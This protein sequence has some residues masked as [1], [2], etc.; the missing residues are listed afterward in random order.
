M[1]Q[2]PTTPAGYFAAALAAGKKMAEPALLVIN[3]T[4]VLLHDERLKLTAFEDQRE[5]PHRIKKTVETTDAQSF[6]DYFN[7]FADDNSTIFVDVENRSFL[8]V[9]DYHEGSAD[10]EAANTPRHGSHLV[11]YKCPLTPEAK[12][13]L[14]NNAAKKNQT[15]FAEF[16]EEGA[17]EI[18]EPSAA[19]M[20]EIALTMQAKTGVDFS[21]GIR[22]DNGQVQLTYREDIQG[23]AGTTGQMKIPSK[24]ALGI[25]LFQGGDRYRVEANFR[26]RL[27][28]GRMTL[29]YDLIRPHIAL[30][31]AVKQ[32]QEKIKA[33]MSKGQLI[34]AKHG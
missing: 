1:S 7:R 17:P 25:Q 13:W 14:D 15:E 2:V 23:T 32:I 33:G 5:R 16:T 31:D 10:S 4:Q 6:I 8:G 21:S 11:S 9:L 12:K 28:A 34:E 22:L 24:I 30:A 19:E 26:Y 29:W 18:V 20:L 27:S 3:G